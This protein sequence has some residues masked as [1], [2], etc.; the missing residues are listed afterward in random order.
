[1]TNDELNKMLNASKVPERN[2]DY[3]ADF[4]KDVSRAIA[5]ADR[6]SLIDPGSV[7]S[8]NTSWAFGL[9]AACIIVAFA[10]GFWRGQRSNSRENDLVVI[11]KYY[12]EI[13]SLFP[14]QLQA[15]V[16]DAKGPRFVLSEAANVP[17]STPVIVRICEEKQCKTVVTFSG[18]KIQVDGATCEVLLDSQGNI[19]LVGDEIAWSSAD[20][21]PRRQMRLE[22]RPMEQL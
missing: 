16:I 10:F 17:Q 6:S 5:R 18:Q 12:H 19:L 21:R 3:W 9:A 14:N 20:P 4:P 7:R 15:V 22:A 1:M 13:E 8:F 2:H 11:Q